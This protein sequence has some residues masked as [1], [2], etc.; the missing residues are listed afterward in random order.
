MSSVEYHLVEKH[1]DERLANK[2]IKRMS[3]A[4]KTPFITSEELDERFG[5]VHE[6]VSFME[7]Y[8][9]YRVSKK[10]E[11]CPKKKRD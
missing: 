7:H 10:Y 1:K 11:G 5:A 8:A 9:I 6:M 4:A 2:L 3:A